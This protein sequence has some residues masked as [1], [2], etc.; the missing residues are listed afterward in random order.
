VDLNPGAPSGG[1]GGQYF[2][3][4][5]DGEAF[6]TDAAVPVGDEHARWVDFGADFYATQS[7]SG[8]SE[9][10]GERLWI[11]W[12]NDWRYAGEIPTSPW[13]GAQSLP[14][15]VMLRT[16]GDGVALVQM[17]ASQLGIL[18]RAQHRLEGVNVGEGTIQLGD[19]GIEGST[20]EIIVEF[21]VG[22][23]DLFGLK[24]R[25]GGDDETLVGYDVEAGEVF[26]DR[27]RSGNVDFHPEF[28]ARHSGPLRPQD[29]RIRLHV[30]VD[31]SSIEVF[32]GGGRTVITDRIFP[33]PESDGVALFAEGGTAKLISLDVWNL[34]SAV[35]G[36]AP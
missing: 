26:V 20:L 33:D 5:F 15:R 12:M 16:T 8:V 6:T 17:P 35:P 10:D 24:I 32:A 13:R 27:T 22:D 2:I 29:N 21:D 34:A 14:R 30:F 7:W 19:R 36:S 23:A 28:A 4:H 9:T 11:A 31:R 1:S 3:G 18:R 25:T